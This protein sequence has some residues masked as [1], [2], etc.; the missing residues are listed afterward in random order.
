MK[1]LLIGIAL[2]ASLV[3]SVVNAKPRSDD[4]FAFIQEDWQRL[5]LNVRIVVHPDLAALRKAA[6]DA[7]LSGD[8][9]T[10]LAWSKIN[11]NP[12][13]PCEIHIID[14]NKDGTRRVI[15]HEL[16]HCIYGRWHD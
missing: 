16:L 4:G 13:A 12:N 15:G 1:K 9:D 6:Y 3:P 2:A 8:S 5:N 7:G 10:P 11:T 14:P